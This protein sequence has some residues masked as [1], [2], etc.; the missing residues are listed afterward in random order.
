MSRNMTDE[1][2]HLL[3][4]ETKCYRRNTLEQ[5]QTDRVHAELALALLNGKM[6]AWRRILGFADHPRQINV[7]P[8]EVIDLPDFFP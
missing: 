5:G 6:I 8:G 1:K 3:W 2:D 7:A 4:S